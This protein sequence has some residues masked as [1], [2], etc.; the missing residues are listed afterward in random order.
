M[1]RE[2]LEENVNKILNCMI[3]EIGLSI[4]YFK[5]YF[6][7]FNLKFFIVLLLLWIFLIRVIK[8]FII[9]FIKGR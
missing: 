3:Y 7:V 2:L 5:F 9:F 4:L 6:V 1:E 8:L